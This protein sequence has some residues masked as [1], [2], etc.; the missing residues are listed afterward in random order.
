VQIYPQTP[1]GSVCQ[2]PFTKTLQYR[3]I[4]NTAEDGSRV[5]LDD[6]NAAAVRWTLNYSGLTDTD[7]A[8][9][10]SFFSSMAGR[11]QSFTF[12][13]PAGNLLTWSEDFS[14]T[15][16]QM[17]TFLQCQSGFTDPTGTQ[18]ATTVTNR[19][20]GDLA[21]AQSVS[22]PGSYLCCFSCFVSSAVQTSIALT[23]G[24]ISESLSVSPVWRRVFLSTTT[25]DGADTSVFGISIPAGAQINVFGMQV[26]PQAQPSTYVPTLDRSGVYPATRFDSDTLSFKSEAP[27][28]NS[29]EIKLYSRLAL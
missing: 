22:V 18:R 12:L 13:D 27:N 28:N 4:V 21:L 15:A 11:L 2:F 23:R 6:P 17:S 20:S 25:S 3:T 26:E 7:V 14:Q 9:Y 19:G 29:C 16:W 24:S 1:N 10:Q 5:V 8:T